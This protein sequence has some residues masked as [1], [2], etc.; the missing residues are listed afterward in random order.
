MA[1]AYPQDALLLIPAVLFV[2]LVVIAGR[3][4]KDE[5]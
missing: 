1:V 3:L 2:L 5:S 4:K